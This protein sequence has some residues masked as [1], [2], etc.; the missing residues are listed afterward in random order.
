MKSEGG[1]RLL[2]LICLMAMISFTACLRAHGNDIDTAGD[3]KKPVDKFEW[4]PLRYDST[5]KYIYLSF[6]D[7][8]QHGTVTCFDLCKKEGVKAS[9][10]MVGLHT[11]QKSDGKQIVSM[12]RD[13]YP[14][15]LLANHS[16]THAL[17]KYHS[18]YHHPLQ[19]EEDFFQAQDFLHVPYKI[20]RLPGNRSWVRNGEVKATDLVHPVAHL[21]DSAGYNVIGWDAEWHF[22][23]KSARPVQSATRMAAEID[24]ALACGDTHVPNHLVLLSHDRMF[25]HP[26]DADSLAKLIHILKQN[27]N[28]VFE[29]V[30][31]YPGLKKPHSGL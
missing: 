7:G 20:V 19:A 4:H 22:R 31:H 13:G 17:G 8:P 24:N 5:K 23:T 15:F 9:F 3:P 18:F 27:H 21:L 26:S 12:I 11:A 29:T 25:Q 28:Y 1:K 16:Y 30:D 10:F 6:D 2:G 14:E